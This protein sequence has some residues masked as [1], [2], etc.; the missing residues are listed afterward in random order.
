MWDKIVTTQVFQVRCCDGCR[1]PIATT[2]CL[3]IYNN[4]GKDIFILRV[5]LLWHACNNP[6]TH[7]IG[8]ESWYIGHSRFSP[9]AITQKQVVVTMRDIEIQSQTCLSIHYTID[10]ILDEKSCSEKLEWIG[11]CSIL[12]W[13]I[14]IWNHN[15]HTHDFTSQDVVM[16]VA[17]EIQSQPC[18]T[19]HYTTDETL[20][21]SSCCDMLESIQTGSI[22]VWN[23]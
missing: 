11:T 20:D 21:G 2:H 8:V 4:D 3:T 1:Q 10:E 13:N 22:L 17:M 12:V 9:S 6:K 18:L 23:L 16:V 15:F 7:N 5:K 19:I 14:R